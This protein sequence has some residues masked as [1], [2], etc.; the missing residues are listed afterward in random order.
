MGANVGIGN[1][2]PLTKLH[3]NDAVVGTILPYIQSTSLSY[4]NNG[5]SV[6]GSNTNN[7]NIGNGLTLYNNVASVG[8]YGPVVAWSSRSS[9]GAYNSTYAFIT[10]VYRGNGGDFNWAAGDLIF[11]TA[12]AYGAT[13]R[14]RITNS[15]D[16]GIGVTSLVSPGSSRRGLQISN[17]TNGA[18]ISLSNSTNESSNPRI[19]SGQYDLGFAAGVTTGII[20]FYTNDVLR[21][22]ITAGGNIG[23][24]TT[25]PV[26][27]LDVKGQADTSGYSSLT[28]VS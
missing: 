5:I 7:T 10:G 8:A 21:M 2:A 18:L 28:L 22:Y 23:I 14:M 9:S 11:G 26:S 13:E 16:V 19:F 27:I 25:S 24:G 15:G 20:Q 4:N 12:E 3:V 6:A 17:S 1:T